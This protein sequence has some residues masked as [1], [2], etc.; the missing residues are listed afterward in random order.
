MRSH[1]ALVTDRFIPALAAS[2]LADVVVSHGGQ[3][4][5][6]TALATGTPIVGVGLQLEQQINLDHVMDAGA[7][8]RIQRHRWRAPVIRHAVRSVVGNRSYRRHAE[9]LAQAMRTMD[10]AATAA[11]RMWEFLAKQ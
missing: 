1:R 3:G 5:V 10:G 7:G 4:T 2:R 6:Q 8:I 9:E 11:D